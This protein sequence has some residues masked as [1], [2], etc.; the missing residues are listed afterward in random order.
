MT[1]ERIMGQRLPESVVRADRELEASVEEASE[2]LAKLRWQWTLDE[3]NPER[4]SFSAYSRQ[5]KRHHSLI[6]RYARG[7][8]IFIQGREGA[9]ATIAECVELAAHGTESQAVLEAVAES[10]NIT[11]QTARRW[12]REEVKDVRG[13]IVRESEKRE[14]KGIPFPVE[15]REEHA[16]RIAQM[17]KTTRE[18]EERERIEQAKKHTAVFMSVD[19]R[20]STARQEV[21]KAITELTDVEFSDEEVELLEREYEAVQGMLRLFGKALTGD[22]GTDWDAELADLEERRQYG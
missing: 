6:T 1:E 13:A 10:N 18:R 15:E 2:A 9:V 17:K 22:S 21:K 19:S 3:S 14:E 7:Y 20:L 5:V 8:A 12:H 4:I 11:P 16:K